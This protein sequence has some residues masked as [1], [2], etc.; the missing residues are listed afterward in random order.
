[1]D[2]SEICVLAFFESLFLNSCYWYFIKSSFFSFGG[3]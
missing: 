2:L 3:I 1:M